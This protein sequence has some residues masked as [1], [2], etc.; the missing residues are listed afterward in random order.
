M[1]NKSPTDTLSLSLSLVIGSRCT[2]AYSPLPFLRSFFHPSWQTIFNQQI[3]H[4][5]YP[6]NV[7]GFE[8]DWTMQ[9]HWPT[10]HWN[11]DTINPT[12]DFSIPGR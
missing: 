11:T 7:D 1:P 3:K 4:P 12:G 10:T 5:Q 6:C 9:R 8:P 2:N